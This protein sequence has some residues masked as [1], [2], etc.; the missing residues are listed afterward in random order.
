VDVRTSI[1]AYVPDDCRKAMDSISLSEWEQIQEVRLRAGDR[2]RL[3]TAQQD[4]VLPVVMSA[5]AVEECFRT[6][7]G[8]AVHSHTHELREGYLTTKEGIRVGIGGTAVLRDG[9]VYTYREITSLC[10]RLPRQ[11]P[12][13]AA[14]LM[15][16]LLGSDSGPCGFLLCGAP[17]SGKTTVL[18]D[19]AL[20]LSGH[21]RVAVVDERAEL[22]CEALS[23]C[24]ILK[25]CPKAVGI[26]QAVRNLSPDVIVADEL[27]FA[28]EWAAVEQS[29]HCGVPLICSAHVGDEQE[30]R[31]RPSL[32]RWL[33][34]RVVSYIAFLPP[35][36]AAWDQTRIWKVEDFLEDRR[37]RVSC[38]RLRRHGNHSFASS[39]TDEADVGGMGDPASTVI[40]GSAVYR[41]AVTGAVCQRS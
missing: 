12:D 36:R 18:R 24:D 8:Q 34:R 28:A 27:G 30:A 19:A 20:Q 7:S 32:M 5:Q 17:G 26:L 29:M 15:P 14:T 40:S 6:L 16:F 3:S 37:D 10:I 11:I 9:A 2:V 25:G 38:V 4:L 41:H 1:T 39:A 35:R 22:V 31:H 13:A 33:R 21:F 23:R